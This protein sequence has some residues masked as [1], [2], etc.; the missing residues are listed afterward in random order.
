MET[1]LQT[2]SR[3]YLTDI[4]RL[5]MFCQHLESTSDILSMVLAILITFSSTEVSIDSLCTNLNI[6]HKILNVNSL[7]N[8]FDIISTN[9]LNKK[10]NCVF[11]ESNEKKEQD[12]KEEGNEEKKEVEEE[13]EDRTLHIIQ[14]IQ[15]GNSS[16]FLGLYQSE[17]VVIKEA[18]FE[19]GEWRTN[20]HA[21]YEIMIHLELLRC[22]A[23]IRW[24]PKM[25]RVFMN[26]NSVRVVY[27]HIPM[28]FKDIFG[29]GA[30]PKAYILRQFSN[31][32]RIVS[33]LHTNDIAHRDIKSENIRFRANGDITLIDF[34]STVC[35]DQQQKHMFVTRPICTLKAR[36][37]ELLMNESSLSSPYDAFK[38]DVFSLMCVFYEMITGYVLFTGSTE[39]EVL[40]DIHS[41][42]IELSMYYS[43]DFN[44]KSRRL[45]RIR[46]FG[47][48][49]LINLMIQ[50]LEIDPKKR[51]TCKELLLLLLNI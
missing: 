13:E 9:V 49:N 3:K 22:K 36:P 23:P 24:F 25:L 5:L 14:T 41:L 18:L 29:S 8:I 12:K 4:D 47:G 48:I 27:E 32:V 1:L 21:I 33:F 37:P 39:T 46:A 15:N 31:L 20:V 11:E 42:H 7:R 10:V 16:V 43:R 44:F 35:R 28:S 51:I 38:L 50:G 2:V 45:K 6:N 17:I 40:S 19:S 30:L 34:D 26:R